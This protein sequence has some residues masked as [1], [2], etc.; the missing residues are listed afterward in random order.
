MEEIY[1]WSRKLIISLVLWSISQ[2]YQSKLVF[3]V[4]I[5]TIETNPLAMLCQFCLTTDSVI[6]TR[7]EDHFAV[8]PEIAHEP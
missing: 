7:Y 3:M 4:I 5:T 8:A 6:E 1:N 2:V